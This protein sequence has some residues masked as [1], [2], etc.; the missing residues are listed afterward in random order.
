M[1]MTLIH[2]RGRDEEKGEDH[3]TGMFSLSLV[4][5]MPAERDGL[6]TLGLDADMSPLLI[7]P[8]LLLTFL[9]GPV[10]L[11]AFL[12]LRF[13]V[14]PGGSALGLA[15]LALLGLFGVL[16]IQLLYLARQIHALG[17]ATAD[18]DVKRRH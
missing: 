2:M 9:I 6:S 5:K 12:A 7:L 11:V 8:C 17:Q 18:C 1:T 10:G 4:V 3:A 14:A 13:L 16:L 15:T